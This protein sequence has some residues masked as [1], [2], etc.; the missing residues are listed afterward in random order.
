MFDVITCDR[1]DFLDVNGRSLGRRCTAYAPQSPRVVATVVFYT[2][3]WPLQAV[4]D[5]A[6]QTDAFL[7]SIRSNP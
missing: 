7:S 4:P 2:R 3:E 5:L 1:D 6:R